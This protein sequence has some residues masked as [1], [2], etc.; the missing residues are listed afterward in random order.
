MLGKLRMSISE[1]IDVYCK[2][3]KQV[4]KLHSLPKHTRLIMD[5]HKFSGIKLGEVVDQVV[6]QYRGQTDTKMQDPRVFQGPEYGCR[7]Y[8]HDV[9]CHFLLLTPNPFLKFRCCDPRM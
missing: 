9:L 8:V 4:F 5:G 7:T 3:S 6:N 1:C 2:M